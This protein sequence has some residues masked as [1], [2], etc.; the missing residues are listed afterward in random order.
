MSTTLK[1]KHK[2]SERTRIAGA[3]RSKVTDEIAVMY[4]DGKSIRDIARDAGRSYGWV[5]R[6]L[7]EA[8][9]TLRGRG[10]NRW[11][12]ASKTKS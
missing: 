10:G 2:I 3:Q 11:K 6:I 4:R 1:A 7:T 12:S 5:H 9:V 8:G